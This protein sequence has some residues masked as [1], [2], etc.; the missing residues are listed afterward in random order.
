MAA[1]VMIGTSGWHYKHWI[2]TVYPNPFPVAQ[3][4]NWY[5]QKLDTVELNNTFYRLPSESSVETWRDSTPEHFRFAVKASRFLTHM[6]KLSAPRAG[7]TRFFDRIE[8]LANK[9]G[10]IL[11]QLPPNFAVNIPRLCAF[12]Y[13]LPTEHRYA[14]E[15]RDQSWNHPEVTQLL[16]EGSIAYCVFELDGYQSP[17]TITT[18]M[19]YVRLHGPAGKYAGSYDDPTLQLWASR[20]ISWR[21]DLQAIYVYFDNDEAGHAFHNALRLREL[22]AE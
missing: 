12:L 16:R 1:R 8:P 21:R 14:F 9:L 22:L 7:L 18:D 3:M 5:Q 11:F 17:L 13:E 15:F 4:L 6:K 10:P 20:I 19:A 2:G